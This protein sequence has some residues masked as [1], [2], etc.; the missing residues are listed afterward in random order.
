MRLRRLGVKAG[1]VDLPKHYD[2]DGVT[3]LG[4]SHTLGPIW[5]HGT[6]QGQGGGRRWRDN[7]GA[8]NRLAII[9]LLQAGPGWARLG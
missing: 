9:F 3:G 5:S 6:D 2:D 8:T 7:G 4:Q 1:P